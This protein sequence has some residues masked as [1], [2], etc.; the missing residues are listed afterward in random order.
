M[1]KRKHNG[2]GLRAVERAECFCNV[3]IALSFIHVS[4]QVRMNQLEL[5]RCS[6][7]VRAIGSI[8]RFG[9]SQK[10][11][12]FFSIRPDASQHNER[13]DLVRRCQSATEARARP[14][15]LILSA[16]G[17]LCSQTQRLPSGGCLPAWQLQS[18]I[19]KTLI[20]TQAPLLSLTRR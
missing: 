16:M 11:E 8:I 10:S 18:H 7:A 20:M 2:K 3:W 17:G 1:S 13:L 19:Q 6:T 5:G 4:C 15:H 9:G 12:F 14:V